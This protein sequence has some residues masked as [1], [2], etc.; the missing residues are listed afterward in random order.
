ML[1]LTA[2][3]KITRPYSGQ[4]KFSFWH[5]IETG[6]SLLITEELKKD[7]NYIPTVRFDN[8]RTK[9]FFIDSRNSACNYLKNLEFTTI[10]CI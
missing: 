1:S 7:M 9:E 6:D 4:S 8:L 5:E 10:S 2:Q 3:I